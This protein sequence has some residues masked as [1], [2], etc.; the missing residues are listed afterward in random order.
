MDKKPGTPQKCQLKTS[1]INWDVHAALPKNW[2]LRGLDCIAYI[3]D[4]PGCI[5]LYDNLSRLFFFS[6]VVTVRF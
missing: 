4:T 2:K 1:S 5:T 3:S 6:T